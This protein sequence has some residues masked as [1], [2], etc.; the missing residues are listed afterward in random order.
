MEFLDLSLKNTDALFFLPELGFVH[1][2]GPSVVLTGS[3]KALGQGLLLK[4]CNT[5]LSS[6][7]LLGSLN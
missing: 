1:K 2:Q 4:L 3:D 7:E 5:V 6:L